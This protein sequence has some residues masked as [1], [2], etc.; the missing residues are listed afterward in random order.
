MTD[1]NEKLLKMLST[2]L[3]MEEKGTAFYKKAALECRNELGKKMFESL[4]ADEIV[5]IERI[6]EIFSS[7]ESTQKMDSKW[8]GFKSRGQNMEAFFRDFTA[9]NKTNVKADSSDVKALDVGIDLEQKA[10]RHY[11]GALPGA[12][13]GLERRFVEKMIAEERKHFKLLSDAKFY[14]T[15]PDG[16]FTETEHHNLD[17]G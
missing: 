11:E 6:K 7:L 2:A 1:H 9:R 17:A 5:H 13:D 4:A 3:E 14:L 10:I 16:Y 8:E 15:D 12:T